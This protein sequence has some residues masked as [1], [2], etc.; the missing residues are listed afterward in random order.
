MNATIAKIVNLLFEDLA[1]SEEVLAILKLKGVVVVCK[2]KSRCLDLLHRL[3]HI[4]DEFTNCFK[5]R[6][7][8]TGH[9]A[10]TD[11]GATVSDVLFN[12][13]FCIVKNTV[14]GRGCACNR[15]VKFIRKIVVTQKFKNELFI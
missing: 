5:R 12:A 6:A 13:S 4:A 8:F 11:N 15:K 2:A 9:R 10:K 14:K 7:V 1:E 3:R